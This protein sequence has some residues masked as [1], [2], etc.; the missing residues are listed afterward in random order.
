MTGDTTA[1]ILDKMPLAIGLQYHSLWWE[2]HNE[3][4]RLS[5]MGEAQE[6]LVLSPDGGG[7]EEL[8][9]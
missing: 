9:V 4:R 3:R 7:R 1:F 5:S 6:I 8:T 2:R